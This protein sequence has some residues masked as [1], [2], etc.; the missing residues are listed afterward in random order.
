MP[1]Q[2]AGQTATGSTATTTW[3]GTG[4]GKAS[5]TNAAAGR[6]LELGGI[7]RQALEMTR[8]RT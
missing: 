3:R 7:E 2:L 8:I 6:A 4:R 1:D 5:R